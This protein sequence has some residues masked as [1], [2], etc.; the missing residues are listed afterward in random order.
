LRILLTGRNGQVGWELERT[1]APLGEVTAV[2]IE[3]LDLRN[4]EAIRETVRR[5]APQ[6]II[7]PAAFT[8][9]DQAERDVDLAFAVNAT[10]P[11]V[12]AE[13]AKRSG[14][15]LVHYS[16]DYV[17]SGTKP[18][19]YVEE[20]VPDPVNVYGHSKLAGERAVRE[21]GCRHVVL[22]TSWVYGGRGRNFLLT[23]LRLA[24]ER[25]EL[26]IV[27]DQI[28]APTWCRA[29]AEVTS[30]IVPRALND[31]SAHGLYHATNAGETS[32]F[33][34]ATEILRIAGVATP[35]HAI[36]T[37]E[38]PTTA[39]RPA[40]SRLDNSKL[41]QVFGVALPEWRSSLSDCMR[42]LGHAV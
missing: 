25:P 26:R 16:T 1:L 19:P 29:L 33:G 5:L 42:E 40:N 12:L 17:F 2:D 39:A 28:G 38:F 27:V 32:W 20:D 8:A 37:S 7:N 6:V 3:E 10:A 23:V 11:A 35:V 21:T 31:E 9:V 4:P 24:G 36:S 22:R 30:A 13:E 14:A 41:R 15:L 34:F 18:S